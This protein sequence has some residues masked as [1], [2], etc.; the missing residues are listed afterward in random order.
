MIIFNTTLHMDDSIHDQCLTYLKEVYIPSSLAGELLVQ[1]MLARIERQHE[2]GGVSYALQFKAENMEA[3][4][5]WIEQAGEKL[6]KELSCRFGN[7]LSGFITF[8]EEIPL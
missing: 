5:Q 8:M 1:P 4:D 6:Q 2:Q 7:K 3:I